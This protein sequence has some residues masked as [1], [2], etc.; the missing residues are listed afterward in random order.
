MMKGTD[1][2]KVRDFFVDSML[3]ALIRVQ[4]KI[5]LTVK[6][7]ESWFGLGG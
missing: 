2:A 6:D 5:R 1:E 4:P 3:L 7:G